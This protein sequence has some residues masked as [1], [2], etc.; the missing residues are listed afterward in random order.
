M[1]DS[2]ATVPRLLPLLDS[3]NSEFWTSGSRGQLSIARCNECS[4]W[5]HPP[6]PICRRCLS[7]DIGAQPVS[8]NAHIRTFTVNRHQ[9]L[10]DA[11]PS[12]Y[13]IAIVELP[14]QSGLRLTTNIVNC[15]PENVYIGM[16]V[17]V[18]FVEEQGIALPLF[19]P[20]GK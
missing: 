6:S 9:W 10:P 2:E 3:I 13:V 5:N 12:P 18:V 11:S 16:P 7:W 15:R 17:R 4:L 19:E 1:V 8:G 20:S 14:E